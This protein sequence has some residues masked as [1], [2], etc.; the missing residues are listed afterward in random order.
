MEELSAKVIA[1]S[2][3][4]RGV[5]SEEM[6]RQAML[7]AKSLNKIIAAHCEDESLLNGAYIHDGAYASAR[8]IKGISSESEWR[9][10]ERDLRL[11]RK[12]A[13]AIICAMSQP[14]NRWS[15]YAG[16]RRRGLM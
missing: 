10:L 4:G 9:Q 5:Q 2:D 12:Q 14:R 1:F 8:G 15:L 13:A 7:K 3:D 6:M 11:V 16:P